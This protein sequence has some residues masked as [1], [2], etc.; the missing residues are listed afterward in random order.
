MLMNNFIFTVIPGKT[1]VRHL[2]LI[3]YQ[4]FNLVSKIII[5]MLFYDIL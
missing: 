4:K 2:Y 3:F 1:F 5:L